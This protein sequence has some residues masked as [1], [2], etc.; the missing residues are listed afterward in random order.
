MKIISRRWGDALE[1]SRVHRLQ[2][3]AS[4][5]PVP[6]QITAPHTHAQ[7][8]NP[9]GHQNRK[10]QKLRGV[11]KEGEAQREREEDKKEAGAECI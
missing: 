5:L 4:A 1:A 11:R 10:T 6:L 9:V 2:N 3:P 8:R 7:A